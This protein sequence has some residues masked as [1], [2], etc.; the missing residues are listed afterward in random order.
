MITFR[1]LWTSLGA[2]VLV[3]L[4]PQWFWLWLSLLLGLGLVDMLSCASPR[5]VRV[6][7]DEPP[8]VRAGQSI[9]VT[10]Q[11]ENRGGRRL[12]GWA[13]DGWQPTAGAADP[14]QK[15]H[16]EAGRSTLMQVQ[17]TPTRH[18]ELSSQHITI[19]SL[20]PLG[21]AGRQV[22]HRVPQTLQVLPEFAS[23]KHLPSK[24]RRLRELDGATA[25]QIR[26]AGTEF[27]SLRDYVRGDDVRSIDWRA[28]AR[29]QDAAGQHLVVRTWRPERDRRVI[30]CLDASRTSAARI[31]DEPR[32]D[33]AL[34]TSLLL[35]ALAAHAGDRV[36]FLAF[37]REVLA[38]ASSSE[39]G[40]FLNVLSTAASRVQPALVEADFSQLPGE[41]AAITTHKSLVVI[42]TAVDSPSLHE[43]LLPVLPALTE[44]H[45]VVVAA[46]RNPELVARA[47]ARQ[48]V[49]QVY[50]AA[51]AERAM[52]EGE[53]VAAELGAMGVEVVQ[54][55]PEALPGAL[56]DTYIRLKATGKL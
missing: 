40:R 8:P 52:I 36:D 38:T 2:A 5:R 48:T 10:T 41:I 37:A 33:A 32:L 31:G 53:A 27:D 18:G 34:E 1:F 4:M 47:A 3:V 14:L 54:A 28:T 16:I 20:G 51:A 30:L 44:K 15:I 35:G 56:A 55:E 23:R 17:L 42:L 9:R 6:V 39:R 12:T 29:R 7:R 11:L 21:L 24:L 49:S 46:V 45:R 26:G 25:V 22:V 50:A 13:K 43:G 19:R